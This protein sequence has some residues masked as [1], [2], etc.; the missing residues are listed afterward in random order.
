M[1]SS[2]A[3]NR[4]PRPGQRVAP[5]TLREFLMEPIP[6][7]FK[8]KLG[9][10]RPETLRP[11]RDDLATVAGGD[12]RPNWPRS[13]SIGFRPITFAR[14]SSIAI[15]PGPPRGP[16]CRP[17]NLENRTR[18]CLVRE[19][20]DEC[21][22]ALGDHTIGEIMSMRAFGPRCL[23]DLLSALES[24]RGDDGDSSGAECRT[25]GGLAAGAVGGVDGGGGAAGRLARRESVRSDD[26]RFAQL[27]ARGGHGGADG[28]GV[29][30]AAL[31]SDAGP[32][33]PG[34]RGP[35]GGAL[36]ERIE[37]MPQLTIEEEL[38]EVFVSAPRNRNAEILI[39]YYGWGD[40]RQ[41]TLTRDRQPIRGHAGADPPDLR[42]A[43]A[44]GQE[45]CRR[46]WPR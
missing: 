19:G 35:P 39:G 12:D 27:H 20:F 17:C 5:Y 15:F 10:R 32:A 41:H 18:R 25:R 14:S 4:Y 9:S 16:I 44:E 26:P 23:V 36:S 40:G 22:Q 21:P 45:P 37:R 29:G 46:S 34:L 43:D 1:V 6:D 33:R 38:I 30:P 13:W 2:K 24:P 8:E 7:E 31:G 3:P 42:Q 28:P 11:G